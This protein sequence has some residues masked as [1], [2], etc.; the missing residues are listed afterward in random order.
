MWDWQRVEVDDTLSTDERGLLRK[1]QDEKSGREL[2]NLYQEFLQERFEAPDEVSKKDRICVLLQA[3]GTKTSTQ[4]LADAVGTSSNYISEFKAFDDI[5]VSSSGGVTRHFDDEAHERGD[6]PV[7]LQRERRR[8][9]SLPANIRADVLDRDGHECLRCG[10]TENLEVHHIVPH[11]QG[12][13]DKVQNLATL[14]H[15]CHNDATLA[16]SSDGGVVP[17]YPSG[18]FEAW[19]ENDLNICGAR[20]TDNTLCRNPAGSC[21]HHD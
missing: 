8:T 20:T 15:D 16:R 10:S 3:F 6:T 17:A 21:P 2:T 12:G 18:E 11:S 19:L 1:Q 5:T 9:N 7:V 13:E 4:A 14:C